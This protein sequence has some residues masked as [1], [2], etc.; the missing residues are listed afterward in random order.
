MNAP[1]ELK[2][3]SDYQKHAPVDYPWWSDFNSPSL[4]LW[5]QQIEHTNLGL[6]QMQARLKAA[7]ARFQIVA[8]N[9]EP[10]LSASMGGSRRDGSRNSNLSASQSEKWIH[11][12]GISSS[13]ELDLWGELKASRQAGSYALAALMEDIQNLKLSLKGQL[14]RSY[15]QWVSL[16]EKLNLLEQQIQLEKDALKVIE[17][18][19][20]QG[21]ATSLTVLQQ[22][23]TLASRQRE[24]PLL[25]K[26]KSEWQKQMALLL[27][28]YQLGEDLE[29]KVLPEWSRQGAEFHIK[30]LRI[31]EQRP[32]L[33]AQWY[34]LLESDQLLIASKAARWPSLNLNF[35][36]QASNSRLAN[37][38]Q[39]L[40]SIISADL[41]APVLDRNK[42]KQDMLQSSAAQEEQIHKLKELSLNALHEVENAYNGVH[43][44]NQVYH[45]LSNELELSEKAYTE[46]KSRYLNG[47]L[48]YI[49][50]LR[51]RNAWFLNQKTKIDLKRDL[52]KQKVDLYMS[53]GWNGMSREHQHAEGR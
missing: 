9:R 39:G 8:A 36:L 34:R 49:N 26:Q 15:I 40:F 35:S 38:P 13:W 31:F 18:R 20:A 48:D 32:D 29:E 51:E 19:F 2:T 4:N 12:V 37:L 47:Q 16:V 52:W 46:A 1:Q 7:E 6:L 11:E 10:S 53:I 44:L 17:S 27:G 42:R 23:E 24:R 41:L 14:A 3:V 45:Q 21:Q 33:K 43:Y 5:M 50:V 25:E 22:R 30:P 28:Q